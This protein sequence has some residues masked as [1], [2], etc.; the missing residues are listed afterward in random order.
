MF[1]LLTLSKEHPL[2]AAGENQP[3]DMQAM[4]LLVHNAVKANFPDTIDPA[5]KVNF[6]W[7]T[8]RKQHN[9]V[10]FLVQLPS[11]AVDALL[12]ITA[13]GPFPEAERQE[14]LEELLNGDD[15]SSLMMNPA[16]SVTYKYHFEIMG[17]IGDKINGDIG[18]SLLR[19]ETGQDDDVFCMFYP[20]ADTVV[21]EQFS[22]Q[23]NLDNWTLTRGSK[24]AQSDVVSEPVPAPTTTAS[25]EP[26]RKGVVKFEQM[27][28]R[29]AEFGEAKYLMAFT[30]S[31]CNDK[32]EFNGN[33]IEF[34]RYSSDGIVVIGTQDI[35]DV[36]DS[37]LVKEVVQTFAALTKPQLCSAGY[38]EWKFRDEP[39]LLGPGSYLLFSFAGETMCIQAVKYIGDETPE[40]PYVQVGEVF[41]L[42][43]DPEDVSDDSGN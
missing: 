4:S 36:E 16:V 42:N 13:M 8:N 14:F 24:I 41:Q 20:V 17:T 43:W 32:S 26:A 21:F 10:Q 6:N 25:S 9:H 3:L 5:G 31:D 22:K 19:G 1:V 28:P 12:M 37:E 40:T 15:I 7:V 27:L 18:A 34:Y 35:S 30:A 39:T 29:S 33:P 23:E 11:V 2:L 38:A